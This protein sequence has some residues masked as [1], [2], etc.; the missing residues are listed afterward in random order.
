VD[1]TR[2]A[3]LLFAMMSI[4]WGIPYL[5]IKV[6]VGGVS[7]PVLVFARTTIGAA[8]L[9]PFAIRGGQLHLV[10]RNWRMI[11]VFAAVEI[12]GPWWLL[13]DAEHRLSSSTTGLMI[14]AVPIIGVLIA[15]LAGSTERLG[16]VRWTGLAIGL[17][18]VAVLAGPHLSGGDAW[19][20]AEALLTALGYA[21][22]AFIAD[23]HL[24]DVPSIPLTAACLT[25]AALVYTPSAALTWPDA[26]PSGKVLASLGALGV[27]CTALAFMVFLALIREAGPSRAMVF[28][29]VNPA[30][31][32]AAGVLILSE[33]LTGLIVASFSL[34]LAGCALAT[35]RSPMADPVDE[36]LTDPAMASNR[37][38]E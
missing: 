14:A 18:G 26:L 32:I 11:A 8:L 24:Q 7:V 30:V 28:T 6:A 33:P 13:S 35:R 2:R 23:R 12:L 31:A 37:L 4:I 15:R 5:L 21:L 3:W 29:Y 16:A 36:V 27:V 10:R 17:A 1:V 34:I 22:A 19:S 20:F 38:V 25:F 9:L